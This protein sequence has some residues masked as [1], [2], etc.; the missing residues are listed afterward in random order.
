MPKQRHSVEEIIRV[1]QYDTPL[2]KN[3]ESDFEQQT[4]SGKMKKIYFALAVLVFASGC[5]TIIKG[6]S[7]TVSINS[8]VTGADVIVNGEPVGQ[9]PFTGPIKRKSGT[10]VTVKKEG[11]QTKTITL[12]TEVESIFWGNIIFGGF[13]GSTTDLTT[14]AM[15]Y[16]APA[17][18]EIDLNSVA[19]K[20]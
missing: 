1:S 18:L 13:F 19:V 5:A 12:T 3:Q 11:Y 16:Y 10:T 20:K 8:N 7:Q 17:T 15:Y 2:V 14:G 4:E 6:T 9:T